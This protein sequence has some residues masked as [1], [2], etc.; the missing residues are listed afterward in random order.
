MSNINNCLILY[1]NGVNSYLFVNGVE[2]YK[3]KANDSE[4][5]SYPVCLG[6]IPKDF[7]TDNMEKT[8]LY[9]YVYNFPIDYDSIDVDNIL[10]IHKYL[11]KKH[12][13]K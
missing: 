12:D 13:K 11:M 5:N 6:N 2:I 10:D 1:H 4:L 7:F 8:R 3:F 9:R